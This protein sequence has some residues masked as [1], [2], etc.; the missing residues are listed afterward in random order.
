VALMAGTLLLERCNPYGAESGGPQRV[1]AGLYGAGSAR[2]PDATLPLNIQQGEWTCPQQA[3]VRVRMTCRCEHTGRIMALCSWHDE[4][5]EHGEMVAG[6][7]RKVTSVVRQR[8]HYE[9]IQRRQ[10]SGCVRCMYPAGN[11]YDFAAAH[12]TIEAYQNQLG[13][14]NEIQMWHS[15]QARDLRQ[16][17]EDVVASFDEGIARGQIHKCPLRL[18]PVS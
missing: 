18:I 6:T 16:K 8:G 5:V 11:G 12:K 10:S 14:L 17:I 3:Q 4:I 9:E 2:T 7:I 1:M 13:Y 15:R